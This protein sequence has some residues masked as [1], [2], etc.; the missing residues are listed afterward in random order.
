MMEEVEYEHVSICCGDAGNLQKDFSPCLRLPDA[1]ECSPRLRGAT[2]TN[3]QTHGGEEA[4]ERAKS[5]RRHDFVCPE[6]KSEIKR[7]YALTGA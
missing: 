4:R 5:P 7:L 1:S 2:K 6:S 3:A